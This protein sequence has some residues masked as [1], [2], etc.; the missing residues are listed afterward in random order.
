MSNKLSGRW[1]T[2]ESLALVLE[3]GFLA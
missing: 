1:R 2:P 3:F